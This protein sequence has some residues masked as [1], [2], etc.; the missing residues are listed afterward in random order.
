MN[1]TWASAWAGAGDISKFFMLCIPI[2]TEILGQVP[3]HP[4]PTPEALRCSP[5]RAQVIVKYGFEPTQAGAMKFT[6]DLQ[7]YREDPELKAYADN[8][9][10]RF[11]PFAGPS[12][13]G[14]D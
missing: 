9:K 14:A 2:A 11:M 7:K 8:L 12:D 1:D 6:S 13:E 10:A 5:A 4:S 3:A